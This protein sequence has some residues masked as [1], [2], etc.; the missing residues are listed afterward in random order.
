MKAVVCKELGLADKLEL[1]SDWP[2]PEMG[3]HDVLI[4]VKAAGLNFPDVLTIQGKYQISA[5]AAFYSRWRV[6][7]CGGSR[8]RQGDSLQGG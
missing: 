5:G 8:G 3:E 1:A 2:D 7:R 4:D 6:L